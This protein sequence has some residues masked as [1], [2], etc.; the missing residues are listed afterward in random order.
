M[1]LTAEEKRDIEKQG[2][3]DRNLP[4]G[5]DKATYHNPKTGQE[6][7][8]MPVDEHNAKMFRRKG[9]VL[10]SASP[11]LRKK[12]KETPKRVLQETVNGIVTEDEIPA[13]QLMDL[14]SQLVA[15]VNALKKQ[16]KQPNNDTIKEE[17]IDLF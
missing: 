6:F 17:E 1:P 3:T 9:W 2:Y 4:Q 13:G 5:P 10:G 16:L 12:W 14:V 11:K 8:N 7:Y 15:E